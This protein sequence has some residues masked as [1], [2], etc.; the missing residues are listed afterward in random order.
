MGP[1]IVRV[2]L[3]SGIP[4]PLVEGPG[5]SLGLIWPGVGAT[6]RTMHWFSLPP[7]GRTVRL[8]HLHAEAVYYVVRGDGRVTDEDTGDSWPLGGG[9]MVYVTAGTGYRLEAGPEGMEFVGGPCPPDPE[10]YRSVGR[11]G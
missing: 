4:L 1:S 9:A 2:C 6:Y 7:H 3:N 8:H 11:E 5:V 10:L